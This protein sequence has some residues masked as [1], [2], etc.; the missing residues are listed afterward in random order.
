MNGKLF[1]YALSNFLSEAEVIS[2]IPY[3]LSPRNAHPPESEN[4]GQKNTTVSSA[5]NILHQYTY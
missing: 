2:K 3:P 5:R 1:C 4:E